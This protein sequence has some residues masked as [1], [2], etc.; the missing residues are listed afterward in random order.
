MTAGT[1]DTADGAL[2]VE[3][4]MLKLAATLGN[5]VVCDTMEFVSD[6]VT[7]AVFDNMADVIM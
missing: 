5:A 3:S 6:E 7:K 4:M 2:K 1:G